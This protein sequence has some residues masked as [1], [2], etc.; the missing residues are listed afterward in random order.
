MRVPRPAIADDTP[1][2]EPLPTGPLLPILPPQSNRLIE[3]TEF[4][5]VLAMD[6]ETRPE[7]RHHFGVVT[8]LLLVA[9]VLKVEIVIEHP[10]GRGWTCAR[11]PHHLVPERSAARRARLEIRSLIR[12]V[13]ACGA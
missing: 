3:P 7:H 12:A 2:R 13:S 5:V 11:R 9:R 6:K 4:P 8:R 1:T 10:V